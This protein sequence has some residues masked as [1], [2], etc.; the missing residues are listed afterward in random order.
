VARVLFFQGSPKVVAGQQ[1]EDARPDLQLQEGDVLKVPAKSWLVLRIEANGY[2][3]NVDEDLELPV[4]DIALLKAPPTKDTIEQQLT[5]LQ[6]SKE[7]GADRVTAYQNR[8]VAGEAAGRG[9][10]K[11]KRKALDFESESAGAPAPSVASVEK[12]L[13]PSMPAREPAA[14]SEMV[15]RGGGGGLKAYED[16][17]AP[18]PENKKRMALDESATA[19]EKDADP[20][21][22]AETQNRGEGVRKAVADANAQESLWEVVQN[23]EARPQPGALPPEIAAALGELKDVQACVRS[24]WASSGFSAGKAEKLLLRF[25]NGKITRVKLGS[26]LAAGS[27]AQA[28]VGKAAGVAGEGWIRIKLALD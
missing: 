13:R 19:K 24:V 4:K 10:T 9:E 18:E 11:A 28:A 1:S 7:I 16:L 23:G 26:G 5:A 8:R 22:P 12:G 17:K 6:T 25:E 27:C 2:V 3:V 21:P 15:V 14:K 20:R